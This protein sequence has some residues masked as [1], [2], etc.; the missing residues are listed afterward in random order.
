[1]ST[2]EIYGFN[3]RGKPYLLGEVANAWRSGPAIWA[4]LEE[5]YLPPFRPSYLPGHVKDE[6]IETYLGYRPTRFTASAYAPDAMK[7]V[8]GLIDRE[9][10]LDYERIALASTFDRVVVFR[11]D[12]SRLI[13]AFH[14]FPGPT[15][16]HDQTEIITP[17]A[18][19]DVSCK[20][21]AWNQTSVNEA[22]CLVANNGKPYNLKR[23][24]IHW[25]LFSI[26]QVE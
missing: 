9:E 19:D 23:G 25:D 13:S 4:Y 10:L 20:A 1:V 6:E 14:C 5:K 12:F 16:L 8:W 17:R 3:P 7:S 22:W 26:F 21:I 24:N 11:R 2:T 15:N 18:F